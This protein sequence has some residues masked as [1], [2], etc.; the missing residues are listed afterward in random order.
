MQ[1]PQS[2]ADPAVRITPDRGSNDQL[3]YFTSSS[4]T[5]DE[6]TLFF[7]SD[8]GGE[9]NLWVQDLSTGSQRQLSQNRE[10]TL[11][12]YVYFSGN[13]NRGFGKASVSLDAANGIAYFLQGTD[14]IQAPR[15][16]SLRRLASIPA[17]QVSAFTHVSADGKLLCVPTTD[18]RALE[19]DVIKPGFN[20]LAIDQRVQAEGL[21]SYLRLFDTRTGKCVH[22]ECV[23]RAWITHVQF[24]PANP[25]LILYNHEWPS[26][27]CGVRRIWLWDGSTHRPL[28]T[29][30]A[31]RSRDDWTCHEMWQR[32]GESVIYHGTYAT[33]TAYLGRWSHDGSLV[34]VSLPDGWRQYGHFT[35]GSRDELAS[36]GYFR[37]DDDDPK[38]AGKWI[39]SLKVDWQAKSI[40]WNPIV[41][42]RSSW[43]SQDS[44][45]HPIFS[46]SAKQIYFTSDRSGKRAVWRVNASIQAT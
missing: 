41:R 45:P 14:I 15:G 23:P 10:G 39:S 22:V 16:G 5:E 21:C 38:G 8:R 30:G 12:S 29:A 31:G 36:D 33:G 13:V 34:E 43:D 18:A 25:S 3:L 28:R 35:V 44:H 19:D 20:N 40:R 37:T 46:P 4:I 11:K 26:V 27:D 1:E 6:Q 9:A 2:D 42:S 17:D 24:S 32:D 7:I